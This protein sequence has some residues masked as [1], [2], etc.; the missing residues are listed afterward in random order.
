MTIE[1]LPN[2]ATE[3]VLWHSLTNHRK[4]KHGGIPRSNLITSSVGNAGEAPSYLHGRV[5]K[6]PI[7]YLTEENRILRDQLGDRRLRLDTLFRLRK[8]LT[9]EAAWN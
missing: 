4:H 9:S 8:L 7:D 3:R 1:R 5:Q 2:Q 6:L